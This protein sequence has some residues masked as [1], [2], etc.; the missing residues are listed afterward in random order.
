MV[1]GKIV[2]KSYTVLNSVADGNNLNS[3]GPC[4]EGELIMSNPHLTVHSFRI[5]RRNR[6]RL[7]GEMLRIK[8]ETVL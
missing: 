5:R 4:L 8:S 3:A 1:R 6:E 2:E 7:R